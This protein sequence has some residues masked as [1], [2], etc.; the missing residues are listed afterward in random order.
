MAIT[1]GVLVAVL[2]GICI[3]TQG[4]FN[5]NVGQS[6]GMFEAAFISITVTFLTITTVMLIFGKGD[7]TQFAQVPKYYLLAG[8]M[9]ATIV[10]LTIFAIRTL[11][12][13]TAI[14]IFVAVQLSV[15]VIFEHFGLFKVPVTPISLMRVLGICLLIVGAALI[16]G[17][18]IG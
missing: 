7:L 12:P 14:S 9:G 4:V 3:A 5:T 10:T 8:V 13:A 1:I 11:G 17:I 16:K 18:K 15:S 2:I 6:T